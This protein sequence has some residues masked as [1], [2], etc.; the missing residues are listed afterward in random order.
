MGAWKTSVRRG[1]QQQQA[2]CQQD[3]T[4]A[5]PGGCGGG[6]AV[7]ARLLHWRWR[8]CVGQGSAGLG[9]HLVAHEGHVVLGLVLLV[10]SLAAVPNAAA[11]S[12]PAAFVIL[13]FGGGLR[14]AFASLLLRAVF[15]VSSLHPASHGVRQLSFP[16]GQQPHHGS[17]KS[18]QSK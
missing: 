4:S 7:G 15:R 9:L 5:R 2:E 11:A 14:G 1:M 18:E 3:R 17:C 8:L 10:G 6:P 16:Q 12:T 13:L